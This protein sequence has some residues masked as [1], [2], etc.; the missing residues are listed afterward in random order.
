M[1]R[2]T[3]SSLAALRALST[4][5]EAAADNVAN[6]ETEGFKKNRVRIEE[7]PGGP[8]ARAEKVDTPGPLV[9]ETAP[10]GSAETV[11]LSNVDLAEEIPNLALSRRFYQA[12]LKTVQAE[13]QMLGSLM[14][15]I[16]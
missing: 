4:K 9:R 10:D 2:P 16:S 7:T 8:E 15:I 6:V 3:S 5:V 12:N 13:D 14:D 11:E 1:I